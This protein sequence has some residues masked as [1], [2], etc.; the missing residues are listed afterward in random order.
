MGSQRSRRVRLRMAVWTAVVAAVSAAALLSW[1]AGPVSATTSSRADVSVSPEDAAATSTYLTDV[2]GFGQ[3]LL[4]NAPKSAEALDGL[5]TGLEGECPGVLSG[6]PNTSLLSDFSPSGSTALG[7]A[8]RTQRQADDLKAELVSAMSRTYLQP[9]EGAAA[10]LIASLNTLQWSNPALTA[11]VHG[12]AAAQREVLETPPPDVCADMRAWAAGDYK[13]LPT[14]TTEFLARREAKRARTGTEDTSGAIEALLTSYENT[15]DAALA[16][17]AKMLER[18]FVTV[19]DGTLSNVE[20]R[21]ETALG[22]HS[23]LSEAREASEHATI[24]GHVRTAAGGRYVAKL[25]RSTSGAG[26]CKLRLST[27]KLTREQGTRGGVVFSGGG[28]CVTGRFTGPDPSVTCNRGLLTISALAP[29][30]ARTARLLLS[31]GRELTSRLTRAPRL[32]ARLGY[33]FQI[34]RGPSPIPTSLTELGAGGRELRVVALPPVVECTKHPVK[35]LP[36][37]RPRVLARGRA[38]H[39][40]SYTIVGERYRFLGHVH[41]EVK[42]NTVGGSGEG[43]RSVSSGAIELGSGPPPP[44]SIQESMGCNPKLYDIVYGVLK[45]PGAQVLVRIAGVLT[46]L[47]EVRLPGSLYEGP[48]LAFGAFT[49]APTQVVVRNAHGKTISEQSLRGSASVTAAECE[50]ETE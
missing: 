8:L 1:L 25:E 23:A 11:T 7:E 22:I 46:P 3:M 32:G 12:K 41:S 14:G 24:V 28:Y 21:I 5:A 18:E 19:A 26:G 13:T 35:Y 20:A 2:N 37:G 36:G 10:L 40:P 50:A 44:F 39:G 9:D 33:Y 17:R 38:P 42:V 15:E 48:A 27:E 29:S 31:D 45:A 47:H 43:G 49:A 16:R 6:A 30:S 4:A 34:V